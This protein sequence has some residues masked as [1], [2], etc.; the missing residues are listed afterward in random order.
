MEPSANKSAPSVRP[1]IDSVGTKVNESQ[2]GNA[3]FGARHVRT[4][5]GFSY[6]R[7]HGAGRLEALLKT[8]YNFTVAR[9]FSGEGYIARGEE[10]QSSVNYKA[11]LSMPAGQCAG[12]VADI[13][14]A[15]SEEFT[16]HSYQRAKHKGAVMVIGARGDGKAEGQLMQ[17]LGQGGATD[18]EGRSITVEEGRE[19]PFYQL[20]MP[21]EV[22]NNES[23]D[24]P[25]KINNAGACLICL[26]VSPGV[27]REENVNYAIQAIRQMPA[28]KDGRPDISKVR[29]VFTDADIAHESITMKRPLVKDGEAQYA[30]YISD[31][32]KLFSD[33]LKDTFGKDSAYDIPDESFIVVGNGDGDYLT[34]PDEIRAQVA[35]MTAFRP[36]VQPFIRKSVNLPKKQAE[37]AEKEIKQACRQELTAYS[38]SGHKHKDA[39][40][41]VEARHAWAQANGDMDQ[42][43]M[44]LGAEGAI[45]GKREGYSLKTEDREL[46]CYHLSPRSELEVDNDEQRDWPLKI[47]NA[48]VCLVT[49]PIGPASK[50]DENHKFVMN[51]MNYDEDH[52]IVMK[53]IRQLPP[54]EDGLPDMNKVRFVFTCADVTRDWLRGQG[55]K[56]EDECKAQYDEYLGDLKASLSREVKKDFEGKMTYEIPDEHFIVVGHDTTDNTYLTPPDKIRAQLGMATGSDVQA[57]VENHEQSEA[58]PEKAPPGNNLAGR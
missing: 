36:D 14:A 49:I 10:K 2:T 4:R 24:W 16:E 26:S 27:S 20:G 42:L 33:R 23:R 50:H 47:N 53:T 38:Y 41:L 35:E 18:A 34:P 8:V 25:L 13:N 22:V 58:T 5:A 9:L 54:G 15:C 32:Q 45:K 21:G 44:R 3:Y 6:F 39:L 12:A 40:V 17:R 30:R 29:F 31:F 19:V 51:A 1:V 57:P 55:G 46:P 28:D 37:L 52:E 48:G 43:M 56:T 11:A 7:E